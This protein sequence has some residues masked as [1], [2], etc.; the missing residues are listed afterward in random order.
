MTI[1]HAYRETWLHVFKQLIPEGLR[2]N[3]PYAYHNDKTPIHSGETSI[4]NS[5]IIAD[6]REVVQHLEAD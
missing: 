5:C 2:L 3:L 4:H 6:W 1:P